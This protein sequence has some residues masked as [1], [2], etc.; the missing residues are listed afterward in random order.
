MTQWTAAYQVSLSFTITWSVLKLMSIESVMSSNHF[1]LCHPL[2]LLPLI[3]P[4]IRVFPSESALHIRSPKY[5]RFS[6]N[7]NPSNEYLGLFSFRIDWFDLL[8]V[9]GDSQ[10]SPPTAQFKSTNSSVLSFLYGP[11]V[12]SI[13]DHWKNHRFDWRDL[14]WQSDVYAF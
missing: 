5:W 4:S 9:Q 1:V 12:T 8:P 2:L 11:T 3:F 13:H 14:C 7:V 6:F 10:A